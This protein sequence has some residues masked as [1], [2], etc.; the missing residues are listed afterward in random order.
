MLCVGELVKRTNR[1]HLRCSCLRFLG[2]TPRFD[3]VKFRTKFM[4]SCLAVLLLQETVTIK[5]LQKTRE[6]MQNYA[7]IQRE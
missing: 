4:Y 3:S 2:S 6:S 5:A 1:R 7:S